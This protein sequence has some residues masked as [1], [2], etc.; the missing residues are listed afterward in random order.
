M[1]EYRSSIRSKKLIR[2]AMIELLAEK[3][4][5][6]IT[7]VDIIRRA[8]LSRNTFYAHYQDVFAVL[9]EVENDFLSEM[10]RYL[11]EAIQ[12]Q[13]FT[14]PL[15]LLQ[16]FQRFVEN[17]VEN[18]RLLLANQNAAAFCEKIKRV[19]IARVME[20]LPTAQVKDTEGFLIFLEC[21]AG[22]FVSLYQKSLNGES[23]LSLEEITLEI[24]QIYTWG[25]KK[26]MPSGDCQS[27]PG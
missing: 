17:H 15:P 7:V 26:Y 20:N 19:F 16:K 3:E 24:N 12:K 14:D 1:K 18:N 4:L 5:S 27:V 23:T 25:L 21:V 22:G 8:D 6:K 9:E 11:D 10:N 13:E 2:R